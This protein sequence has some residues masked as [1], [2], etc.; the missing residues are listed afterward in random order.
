LLLLPTLA[1]LQTVESIDTQHSLGYLVVISLS[2]YVAYWRDKR[3][4]QVADRRVSER[5]LHLLELAGGCQAPLWHSNSFATKPPSGVISE[6]TGASSYC[7]NIW[8]WI[9][10]LNGSCS[11]TR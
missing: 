3:R 1:F 11:K 6:P 8:H 5:T 9:T 2:T 7:T 4:A 10:G